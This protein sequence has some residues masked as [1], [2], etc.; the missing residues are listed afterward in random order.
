MTDY[1]QN[2]RH[3][4]GGVTD[5]ASD[6]A[7]ELMSIDEDEAEDNSIFKTARQMIHQYQSLRRPI[8]EGVLRAGETLNIVSASKIG[9]SWLALDLAL[10]V[11][12]GRPWLGT[13]DV[14]QGGVLIV[15]NELHPETLADR[16]PKVAAARGLDLDEFGDG[17][18]VHTLRGQN[19]DLNQLE[20]TFRKITPGRFSVIVLDALYRLQPAGMDEN[21]NNAMM[22]LYNKID[23]YADIT[24]AAFVVVHHA[25]KGNQAGKSVTDVGSGGSAQSRATD[26]HFVLRD[27]EEEDVVVAE[28]AVRSWP[29]MQPLCLRWTFP[30]WN[31]ADG[32]DPKALRQPKPRQ[33][34]GTSWT[35]EAFVEKF[36]TAEPQEETAI[37]SRVTVVT[38]GNLSRTTAKGLM[39]EACGANLAYRWKREKATDRRRISTQ[40]QMALVA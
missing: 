34:L 23:H 35:V 13:F 33:A 3:R 9:K 25:T 38:K 18:C 6:F 30:V 24:G 21:G 12:T 5:D 28:S 8:I 1:N 11:V 29:R 22:L 15:D 20:N 39:A 2:P 27:H 36:I 26:S 40:P 4:K 16:T 32:L 19:V 14:D 17:L 10:S 31:P 37:L 7:K